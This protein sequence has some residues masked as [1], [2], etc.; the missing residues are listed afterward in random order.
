M[1]Y[2]KTDIDYL[3]YGSAIFLAG[4]LFVCIG[5]FFVISA[6][7]VWIYHELKHVYIVSAE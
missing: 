4:T 3:S 7:S 2:T 6:V 5:S 1:V